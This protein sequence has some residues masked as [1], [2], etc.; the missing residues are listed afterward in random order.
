MRCRYSSFWDVP[1]A[2]VFVYQNKGSYTAVSP[3]FM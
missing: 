3:S 2:F 1:R